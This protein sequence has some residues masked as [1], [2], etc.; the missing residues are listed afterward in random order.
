MEDRETER[1]VLES[2]ILTGSKK[3]VGPH[4][5]CVSFKLLKQRLGEED[6]WSRGVLKLPEEYCEALSSKT[7]TEKKMET[8]KHSM[9]KGGWRAKKGEKD[10]RD[11]GTGRQAKQQ[12]SAQGYH[13]L[14][15][16]AEMYWQFGEY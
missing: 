4:S 3:S 7:K 9:K 16:Q 14:P 15:A 2:N 6:G 12:I 11:E 8:V 13:L 1:A 10:R 5:P